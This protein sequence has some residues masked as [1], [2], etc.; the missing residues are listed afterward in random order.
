MMNIIIRSSSLQFKNPQTGHA[1]RAI[2]EHYVGRLIMVDVDGEE[3]T[4]SF[5]KEEMPFIIEKDDMEE[6]IRQRLSS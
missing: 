4:L 6:I 3:Q 5:N 1:T 2:R